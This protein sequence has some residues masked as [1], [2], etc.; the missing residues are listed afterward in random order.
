M[1]YNATIEGDLER[2]PIS[3]F[4]RRFCSRHKVTFFPLGN[5]DCCRIDSEGGKKIHADCYGKAE[6]AVWT[7]ETMKRSG[8]VSA[9]VLLAI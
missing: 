1:I 3:S 8:I 5:A 4:S 6:A 2:L 9:R 7:K